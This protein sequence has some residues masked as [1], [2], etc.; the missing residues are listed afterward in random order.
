MTP[1]LGLGTAICGC[2]CDDHPRSLCV[3]KR[4]RQDLGPLAGQPA[5]E[6]GNRCPLLDEGR[7]L[8]ERMTWRMFGQQVHCAALSLAAKA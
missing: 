3:E 7:L 1:C 2:D 8:E 6:L 4:V 5:V